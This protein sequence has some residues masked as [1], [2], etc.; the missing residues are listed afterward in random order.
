MVFAFFK[1]D[2]DSM[3]KTVFGE[4]IFYY[5]ENWAYSFDRG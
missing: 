1:F 3:V 2:I 4:T 5:N